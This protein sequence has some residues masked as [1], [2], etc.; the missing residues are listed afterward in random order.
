ML[1]GRERLAETLRERCKQPGGGVVTI[2]GQVHRDEIL[3]F[4]AAA[5]VSPDDSDDPDLSPVDA[6]Y[7]D[8]HGAAK[9]LLASEAIPISSPLA[10]A[11]TVVVPSRNFAEHL[12]AGSRHR[13]IVPIP[14]GSQPEMALEAAD[15]AVAA[16][17]LRAAGVDHDRAHELGSIARMS[18]MAL[19]RRLAVNPELYAPQWATDPVDETLRRSLLLH[20]WDQSRDGDREIVERFV[21]RP[22]DEVAE[23]LS[24]LDSGDAPMILTSEIRH[25]ISPMDMWTLLD[26]Q[27]AVADITAFG[28]IAHD[29]LT[30]PDP[31]Y[32]RTGFGRVQAQ[33]DGLRAKYS[34]TIKRGIA[35]TLALMGSRPPTLRGSVT[36][37]R[38]PRQGSCGESSGPRTKARARGLGAPSLRCCRC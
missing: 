29:V 34:A 17:R 12:P 21:G 18:L 1:A 2:G 25:V 8:D 37:R 11:L 35:T 15:A 13:M 3:A 20:S 26:H 31:L 7:V 22:H 10:R 27:L 9:R 28:E 16:A 23:I 6:M 30:E 19:R 4:V 36:P 24:K 14:G 38:A 33:Y 32:G 5:L